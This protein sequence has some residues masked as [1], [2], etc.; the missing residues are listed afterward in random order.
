LPRDFHAVVVR[1]VD[2]RVHLLE[3]HAQR[4]VVVRVGR[5]GVAG[6]IGLDPL[7]AI[8]DELA[9]G[10]AAFIGAVDQ[11]HQALHADLAKIGIPVHQAADAADLAP[12]GCQPRP[13]RKFLVDG[14]LQPKVDIE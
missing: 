12:A 6:R 8:L 2:H 11:Q 7:D 9:H 13:G 14:P 10:A 4:V 5:R 1:L 3:C